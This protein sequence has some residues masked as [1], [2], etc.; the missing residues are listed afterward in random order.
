ML[1]SEAIKAILDFAGKAV[2]SG[3]GAWA[4]FRFQESRETRKERGERINALREALFVLSSQR[5][6]LLELE[7]QQLEPFRASAD[8]HLRLRPLLAGRTPLPLDVGKLVFLIKLHSSGHLIS[9]LDTGEAQ[10][11]MVLAILEERRSVHYAMQDRLAASIATADSLTSAD[12]E[13]IVG[14]HLLVP[15]KS[16]TD[17]LYGAVTDALNTNR[18]NVTKIQ[19]FMRSQF[20]KDRVPTITEDPPQPQPS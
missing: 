8:R 6:F 1:D 7:R 5:N 18:A 14:R 17:T 4:A 19:E 9:D 2:A 3:V 16:L 10:F 20:P 15:L 13:S 12:F 11:Q